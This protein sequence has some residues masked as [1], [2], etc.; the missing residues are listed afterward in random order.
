M[1]AKLEKLHPDQEHKI[2]QLIAAATQIASSSLRVLITFALS[3][4]LGI[5][6][7]GTCQH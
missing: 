1:E 7:G 2:N 5:F 4:H 3:P 6:F